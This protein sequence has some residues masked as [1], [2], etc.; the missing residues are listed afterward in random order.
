[1]L[2]L[3][4]VAQPKVS[5]AQR[6]LNKTAFIAGSLCGTTTKVVT[7]SGAIIK[8]DYRVMMSNLKNI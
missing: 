1:M 5:K 2:H 7:V 8:H 6:L 3:I 4:T